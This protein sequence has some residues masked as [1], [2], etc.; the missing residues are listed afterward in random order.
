[1]LLFDGCKRNFIESFKETI[2]TKPSIESANFSTTSEDEMLPRVD[3]LFFC[4][5]K[6]GRYPPAEDTGSFKEIDPASLCNGGLGG[7]DSRQAS[8]DN[9]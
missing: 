4:R 8:T 1:M 2:K 7:S 3:P 6:K 5:F 9:A